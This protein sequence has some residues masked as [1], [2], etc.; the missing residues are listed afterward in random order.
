MVAS[1]ELLVKL[2][3]RISELF[4]TIFPESHMLEIAESLL[5]RLD[6]IGAER[7]VITCQIVSG[8]LRQ[9]FLLHV[10]Y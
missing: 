6:P 5:V 2:I 1:I 7:R 8:E 10:D 9:R 4:E 3:I